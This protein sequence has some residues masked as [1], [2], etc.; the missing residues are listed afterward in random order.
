VSLYGIEGPGCLMQEHWSAPDRREQM[1]F[2][3]RAVESEPS[4][5]GLSS[6]MLA[7]GTKPGVRHSG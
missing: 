1:L 6:H 4:L 5:S 7:I 2:A 3:A